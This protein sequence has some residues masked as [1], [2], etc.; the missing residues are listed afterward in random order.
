MFFEVR[1]TLHFIATKKVESV[2]L[3]RSHAFMIFPIRIHLV[4]A[5]SSSQMIERLLHK[6]EQ[7]LK[8]AFFSDPCKINS[9]APCRIF[10]GLLTE[11][12]H[13]HDSQCQDQNNDICSTI[14]IHKNINILSLPSKS[15]DGMPHSLFMIITWKRITFECQKVKW[16]VLVS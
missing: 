2:L 16:P 1:S 13:C 11:H 5:D 7:A 14:K 12:H 9:Q 6:L 10:P 8:L 15:L 4:S 3:L